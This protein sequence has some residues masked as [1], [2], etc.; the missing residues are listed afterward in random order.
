[1]GISQGYALSVGGQ[2][3]W[4]QSRWKKNG[5]TKVNSDG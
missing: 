1:M 2:L 5:W 3:G 4:K